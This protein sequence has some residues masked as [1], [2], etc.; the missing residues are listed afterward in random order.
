MAGV[1]IFLKGTTSVE[2]FEVNCFGAGHCMKFSL[3][4]FASGYSERSYVN[5]QK[6][7]T[8][9]TDLGRFLEEFENEIRT[10]LNS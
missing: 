8:E 9:K 4:L 5:C 3:N 10:Y 7:K 1:A 2:N 6:L